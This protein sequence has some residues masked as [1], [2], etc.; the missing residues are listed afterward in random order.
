MRKITS[1][2]IPKAILARYELYNWKNAAQV[3]AA[4]HPSEWQDILAVLEAFALRK[5]DYTTLTRPRIPPASVQLE[6][7]FFARNWQ[8][9][10]V[11]TELSLDDEIQQSSS[12]EVAYFRN[13]VGVDCWWNSDQEAVFRILDSFG[14][15]REMQLMD[16]GC[17]VTRSK[18]LPAITEYVG[19]RIVERFVLSVTPLGEPVPRLQQIGGACPVLVFALTEH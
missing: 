1:K 16:A 4:S 6:A 14:I 10:K 13:R 7:E 3:I 18:H 9:K 8:S 12:Y 15:V 11:E 19:S 2:L 5:S 17:I